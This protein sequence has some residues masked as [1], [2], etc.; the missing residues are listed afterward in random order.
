MRAMVP[1]VMRRV[2]DAMGRRGARAARRMDARA[3][4]RRRVWTRA[5]SWRVARSWSDT[6]GRS[7]VRGRRYLMYYLN[8]K[9]ERVYTLKVRGRARERARGRDET[10]ARGARLTRMGFRNA[11]DRARR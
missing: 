10:Y 1:R 5:R 4:W 11:E 9:G 8:E 2:G 3:R 7:R 6:D